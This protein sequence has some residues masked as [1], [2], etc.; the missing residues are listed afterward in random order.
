MPF[1]VTPLIY[2]KLEVDNIPM[3]DNSSDKDE[4]LELQSENDPNNVDVSRTLPEHTLSPSPVPSVVDV[5]NVDSSNCSTY[6]KY[7]LVNNR[8][9]E[10]RIKYTLINAVSRE[11]SAEILT[12]NGLQ[13]LILSAIQNKQMVKLA[14]VLFPDNAH[15]RPKKLISEPYNNWKDAVEDLKKHAQHSYHLDSKF[16]LDAFLK[17]SDDSSTRIDARMNADSTNLIEKTR[18]VL[19]SILKCIEFC[20]RRGIALRGH[21]D[22]DTQIDTADKIVIIPIPVISKS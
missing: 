18:N 4:T 9:P 1:E 12:E 7:A 15:R 17:T 8:V 16:R 22:D 13:N 21:C 5:C 20:G 11:H 6:M 3:Q 2:S 14:C 19:K 10:F